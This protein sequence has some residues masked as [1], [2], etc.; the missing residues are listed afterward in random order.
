MVNSTQFTG[1]VMA[2]AHV[3]GRRRVHAPLVGAWTPGTLVP[4]PATFQGT[5]LSALGFDMVDAVDAP[6][7]T[8]RSLSG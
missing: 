7:F 8:A 6:G 2:Y 3:A 4:T 1:P 5:G